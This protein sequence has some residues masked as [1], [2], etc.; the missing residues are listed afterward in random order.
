MARA[1]SL[2]CLRIACTTCSLVSASV[3]KNQQ[4]PDGD[5]DWCTGADQ[6]RAGD[7]AGFYAAQDGKR[8]V[9]PSAD[10]SHC[11][12][13]AHEDASHG[14]G[15][16]HEQPVRLLGKGLFL[17][18]GPRGTVH[19]AVRVAQTRQERNVPQV[20]DRIFGPDVR[21]ELRRGRNCRNTAVVDKN[22]VVG[23]PPG[24]LGVGDSS[25][26][27]CCTFWHVNSCRP[28]SPAAAAMILRA[29]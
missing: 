4:W 27:K 16:P 5:C 7:S 19:V 11:G 2:T 3:P 9:V 25:G 17:C 28:H 6:P 12:G 22:G 23:Q 21:R 13:P 15:G 10:V 1:P 24:D 20:Q 8:H 29:L 18:V 26:D 14:V